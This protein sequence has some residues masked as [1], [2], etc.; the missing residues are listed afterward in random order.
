MPSRCARSSSR[1]TDR[2][3]VIDRDPEPALARIFREEWGRVLASLVGYLHDFDLAED[4]AQAA[5]ATAAERWPRDG[6]PDNPAGWLIR[7]ARNDA[8]DQLRRRRTLRAKLSQLDRPSEVA[9]MDQELDRQLSGHSIRDERLELLFMCCHPALSQDA[10]VA[11]TL[12]AVGGLSTQEIAACFLVAPEAM[13]RRLS[14]AKQKIT[15]AAI[16]FRVPPDHLLPERLGVV[17]AVI[18]LVYNQGYAGRVDLAT[19]A[20]RLGR[21]L[22]ALMPDEREVSGLLALMLAHDARRAARSDGDELVLLQDQD[23]S[24]WD[25]AQLAEARALADRAITGRG[26]YALQA[27]IAVL[28][29]DAPVDWPQVAGLYAE[30]ADLTGSPVVQ[31]NRAVA[32]AQAG[33]PQDALDLVDSLDR[34][35]L[36][37]YQYLH[38]TRA[39][40]LSRL[41]RRQEAQAAYARAL[42]LARDDR[43]R[44]FL[45]RR[46]EEL[47]GSQS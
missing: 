41:D 43:E 36:D 33:R 7:T 39:E 45:R 10:Q 22:L 18:Y 35:R 25:A 40:L 34:D 12:R 1:R 27:A 24:L 44:R 5:F 17:L 46:L 21:I 16:P 26:P 30:L 14:R 15:G 3:L 23:R 11:L 29:T 2:D 31:L 32:V 28:Q 47:H 38:S 9:P 42:E 6:V 19:E 8:I 13:K 4:V 20:I 37:G